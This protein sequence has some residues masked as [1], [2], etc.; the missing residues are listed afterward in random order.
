MGV[1]PMTTACAVALPLSYSCMSGVLLTDTHTCQ[2]QL[3]QAGTQNLLHGLD[4]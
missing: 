1:E 3:C 4:S 2:W